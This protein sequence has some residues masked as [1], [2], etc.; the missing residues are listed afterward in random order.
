LGVIRG[1]TASDA[2]DHS[3]LKMSVNRASMIFGFAS[4]VIQVLICGTESYTMYL[5]L[6]QAK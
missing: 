4:W 6:F 5:Q 2:G 1:K 3:I